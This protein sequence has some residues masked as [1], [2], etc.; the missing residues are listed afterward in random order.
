ML[1]TPTI[2]ESCRGR[3]GQRRVFGEGER[4]SSSAFQHHRDSHSLC[5]RAPLLKQSTRPAQFSQLENSYVTQIQPELTGSSMLN[6][7]HSDP[8]RPPGPHVVQGVQYNAA[9]RLCFHALLT[10][11]A[12]ARRRD[13]NVRLVVLPVSYASAL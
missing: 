10:G 1:D 12:G 4:A 13:I 5:S 2:L 6:R 8:F 3:A 7:A 9:R 11:R